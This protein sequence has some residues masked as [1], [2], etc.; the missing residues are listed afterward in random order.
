[1]KLQAI[2]KSRRGYVL[3]KLREHRGIKQ[4][5]PYEN[6]AFSVLPEGNRDYFFTLSA[7]A[8]TVVAAAAVAA[9]S[10]TAAAESITAAVES[11]A[12]SSVFGLLSQA[13]NVRTLPTNRRAITFFII[14]VSVVIIFRPKCS[15]CLGNV[16]CRCPKIFLEHP[17]S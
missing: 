10:T 13:A 11:T 5:K 6:R 16:Q 9:E 3:R 1:M 2:A 4:K 14:R 8:T 7:G 17:L 12:A 15:H